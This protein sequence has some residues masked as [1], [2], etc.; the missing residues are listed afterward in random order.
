M[1]PT[2]HVHVIENRHWQVGILPQTGASVAFGRVRFSGTWL[3]VL[4]PTDPADYGN[5]SLCSSFIMLPWANRIGEG[6]ITFDGQ[7][8]QLATAP[9]DGTARHGDVRKRPW[10]VVTADTT[11]ISL[12]FDSAQHSDVNW[13][14]SFMAEATYRLS[15]DDLVFELALTNRDS[16]PFPA[17]FGHHPY[18]V[19]PT[20]PDGSYDPANIPQVTIPCARYFPLSDHFLATGAPQPITDRLDFRTARPLDATVYNDLLTDRDPEQAV[21]I[22]Y[23]AWDLTLDL[24][25]DTLFR[26]VLLFT[27]ADQPFF[28]VEPQTNANDGFALYAQGLPGS[29][30]FVLEP[31]ATQP[32]SV[33]L[34]RC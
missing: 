14:F 31:G 17:G 21:R 9:D 30:V 28:A 3:D 4:R 19:R 10:E 12:R 20:S 6:K 29:G 33:R 7:T 26:H 23:P 11:Q 2:P 1:T 32:G 5:S 24:R 16:R 13:P 25:A 18:F 27:P 8:Y 22:H 34:T 15:D